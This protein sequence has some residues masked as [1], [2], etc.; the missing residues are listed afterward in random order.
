MVASLL[1]RCLLGIGKN[2]L[3][4][5]MAAATTGLLDCPPDCLERILKSLTAKER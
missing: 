4:Q 2:F 1:K 3:K 5:E